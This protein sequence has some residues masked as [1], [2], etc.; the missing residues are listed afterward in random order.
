MTSLRT[1]SLPLLTVA[2]VA[3]AD[4]ASA[5]TVQQLLSAMEVPS[6]AVSD[7][8]AVGRESQAA[9]LERLGGVFRPFKWSPKT[10]QNTKGCLACA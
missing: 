4:P 7:A 2:L 6:G 8:Q 1:L 9:V 5:A 10:R 3:T